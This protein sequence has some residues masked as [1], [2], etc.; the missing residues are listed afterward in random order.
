MYSHMAGITVPHRCGATSAP[1]RCIHCSSHYSQQRQAQGQAQVRS[2]GPAGG[3]RAGGPAAAAEHGAHAAK[4]ADVAL[5]VEHRAAQLLA[6][7]GLLPEP[8]RGGLERRGV[9][10]GDVEIGEGG[11]GCG[12]PRRNR[13][14]V[15]P[16]GALFEDRDDALGFDP[17]PG[18]PRVEEALRPS[19]LATE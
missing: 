4:H 6:Q 15:D 7:K 11:H 3:A 2:D 5:Q 19:Q 14:R 8:R 18:L 1:S 10:R 13:R 12:V 16:S 9:S 17:E